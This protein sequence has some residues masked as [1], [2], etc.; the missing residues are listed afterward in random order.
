M[1]AGLLY[2]GQ[3][4]HSW[5]EELVTLL[6]PVWRNPETES[7]HVFLGERRKCRQ[8]SLEQRSQGHRLWLQT[9]VWCYRVYKTV[10]KPLTSLHY[11][12]VLVK[13]TLCSDAESV[14]TAVDLE[15]TAEENSS[16]IRAFPPLPST[17]AVQCQQ[18]KGFSNDSLNNMIHSG[19]KNSSQHCLFKRLTSTLE[20]N[21]LRPSHHLAFSVTQL[22]AFCCTRILSSSCTSQLT[23]RCTAQRQHQY[24]SLISVKLNCN[25][26]SKE[27]WSAQ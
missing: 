27:R 15:T 12:S 1:T 13:T 23:G 3:S 19:K 5:T 24:Y 7:L 4:R 9:M 10:F 14:W 21:V 6:V 8:N 20:S 18:Q 2:P 22:T 11:M 25:S 17:G 16:S 26:I